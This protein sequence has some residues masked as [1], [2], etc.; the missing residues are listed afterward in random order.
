MHYNFYPFT[1]KLSSSLHFYIFFAFRIA[2]VKISYLKPSGRSPSV[3]IFEIM[4]GKDICTI[5]NYWK[6]FNWLCILLFLPS[7]SLSVYISQKLKKSLLN[8]QQSYSRNNPSNTFYYSLHLASPYPIPSLFHHFTYL[9]LLSTKLRYSKKK[10]I[11]SNVL[12]EQD[13]QL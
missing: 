3:Q 2:V 9:L 8:F 6:L 7:S 12:V 11:L 1:A 13:V 5:S 10:S 4:H